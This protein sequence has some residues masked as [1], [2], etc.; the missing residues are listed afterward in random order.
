M[1]IIC[2]IFNITDMKKKSFIGL[3]FLSFARGIFYIFYINYIKEMM[4]CLINRQFQEVYL[5]IGLFILFAILQLLVKYIFDMLRN[6]EQAALEAHV[7]KKY[8]D[9]LSTAKISELYQFSTSD[10]LTRFDAEISRIVTFNVVTLIDIFS[11]VLMLSFIIIYI[12]INNVFLL[13]FLFLTPFIVMLTKRF[14]VKSRNEYKEGQNALIDRNELAKNIVDY[15][16]NIRAYLAEPFFIAKYDKY[17]CRFTKHKRKEAFYN[18]IFW[19]ANIAGYQCIYMLFYIVGG[20]LAFGGMFEFGIIISLFVLLDPLIIMI[21]ALANISPA[22]YKAGVSIDFYNDIADLQDVTDKTAFLPSDDC[23]IAFEHL[24]YS[25][26]NRESGI[27]VPVLENITMKFGIGQKIAVIGESGSGKSTLLKLLMGYD[28]KYEGIISINNIEARDLDLKI[29]KELFSYL[30]QEERF[31]NETIEENVLNMIDAE[32]DGSKMRY[33]AAMAEIDKDIQGFADSYQTMMEDGGQNISTGQRQ[34]ICLL[35][36]LIKER[37][38]LLLDESFSAV[39][40]D[41]M[42]KI[43]DNISEQ[44]KCGM[45]VIMHTVYEAVLSRFDSIIIMENGRIVSSGEY[46]VVRHSIHYQKLKKI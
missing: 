14:G 19:L 18:R 22:F 45:V 34:R 39:D 7:K 13:S 20:F 41:T 26:Q 12:G 2:S 21:Q 3:C 43:I 30:P 1:K 33:Y 42:L 32:L 24:N 8:F 36:A 6:K 28:D 44:K 40:P 11:D 38:M 15:S 29:L 27:P 23:Q 37:P 16:D 31:L 9:K 17:E 5:Y 46:N 10:I 4:N 25:Y 35:M